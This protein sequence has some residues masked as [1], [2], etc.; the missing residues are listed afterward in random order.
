MKHKKTSVINRH[1][2]IVPPILFQ[3]VGWKDIWNMP[4]DFE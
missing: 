1:F 3:A 4:D 2:I